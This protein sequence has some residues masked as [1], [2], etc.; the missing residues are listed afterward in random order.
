MHRKV[1]RELFVGTPLWRVQRLMKPLVWCK[2]R[3]QDPFV[4]CFQ[5]GAYLST[6][7]VGQG[8]AP[9]LPIMRALVTEPLIQPQVKHFLQ[10]IK[11]QRPLECASSPQ[12]ELPLV[13]KALVSNTNE[14]LEHFSLW[15]LSFNMAMLLALIYA[16]R[17]L[18]V[19]TVGWFI[20]WTPPLFL[21][22]Q[23]ARSG[24]ELFRWLFSAL[25]ATCAQG[26]QECMMLQCWWL[27]SLRCVLRT[28]ACHF[29]SSCP[30]YYDPVGLHLRVCACG[31]NT[32]QVKL[33]KGCASVS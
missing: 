9:F 28:Y 23:G 33:F 19:T 29:H 14:P 25:P 30:F 10:E 22:T 7:F 1:G 8:A 11:R 27:C 32:G 4:M 24:W 20:D 5:I 21:R 15:A 26:R 13:L 6:A 3:S 17:V 16:K 12:W 18:W 2:Q 31:V